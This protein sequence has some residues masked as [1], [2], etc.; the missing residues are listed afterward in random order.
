[1]P[2]HFAGGIYCVM[3]LSIVGSVFHVDPVVGLILSVSCGIGC[4]LTTY[5]EP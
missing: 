4:S 3:L 1:M 2:P 5:F